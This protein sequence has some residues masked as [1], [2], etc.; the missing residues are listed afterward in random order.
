MSDAVPSVFAGLPG[1]F[2]AHPLWLGCLACA[3]RDEHWW[4][5][6]AQLYIEKPCGQYHTVIFGDGFLDRITILDGI[7]AN[8][9][10]IW[11]GWLSVRPFLDSDLLLGPPY[12]VLVLKGGVLRNVQRVPGLCQG[13]LGALLGGLFDLKHHSILIEQN[14]F[15]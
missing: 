3:W 11:S 4:V 13:D 15:K 8:P 14:I 2:L 5:F 6:N 10:F 12:G 9:S 7:N 1:A